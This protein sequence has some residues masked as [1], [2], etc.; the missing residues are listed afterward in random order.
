MTGHLLMIARRPHVDDD[1]TRVKL[2]YV[3]HPAGETGRVC[4]GHPKRCVSVTLKEMEDRDHNYGHHYRVSMCTRCCSCGSSPRNNCISW[5][6]IMPKDHNAY[7]DLCSQASCY[8]PLRSCLHARA[9]DDKNIH[10]VR[11]LPVRSTGA[12]HHKHK[13]STQDVRSSFSLSLDRS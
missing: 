10:S 7:A 13:D 12:T 11:K 2:F 3:I 1:K 4:H 6:Y 5:M 8:W 9:N